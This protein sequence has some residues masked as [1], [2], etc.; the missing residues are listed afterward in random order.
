M[1]GLGG[2]HQ[3]HIGDYAAALVRIEQPQ[4]AKV[5]FVVPII[6]SESMIN[7]HNWVTTKVASMEPMKNGRQSMTHSCARGLKRIEAARRYQEA[8]PEQYAG[9][10][11]HRTVR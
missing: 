9:R 4:P 7:V 1:D 6:L 3:G 10:T 2:V 11:G 8:W 5:A